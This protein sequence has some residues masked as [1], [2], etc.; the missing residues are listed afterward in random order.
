MSRVTANWTRTYNSYSATIG[1]APKLAIGAITNKN[2]IVGVPGNDF[3]TNFGGLTNTTTLTVQAM[4][5]DFP[6]NP[7]K[8]AIATI[9]GMPSD[10][11]T[12]TRQVVSSERRDGIIYIT[13]GDLSAP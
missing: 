6:T 3:V 13:L 2:V 12:I 8:G 5:S 4:G 10:I 7:T 1:T 11:G 9:T